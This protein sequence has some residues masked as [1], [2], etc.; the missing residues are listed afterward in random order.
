MLISK[1]DNENVSERISYYEDKFSITLPE[2]YKRFLLKYNGGYTP[3]TKFKSGKLSSDVRGYYGLGDV[4]LSVDALSLGE[5]IEHSLFPIAYD[6]FGNYITIGISNDSYGKVFFQ[7]HELG[8]RTDLIC[9]EFNT[10]IE[11]CKSDYIDER[12]KLSIEE[13]EADLIARGKGANISEGLRKMWQAEID[14]YAD[15]QQEEVII[16]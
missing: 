15:F 6:S 7:D 3:E 4:K 12:F 8:G 9:D 10:F 11:K 5:W 16:D 14:K 13:R 2:Q 1:F